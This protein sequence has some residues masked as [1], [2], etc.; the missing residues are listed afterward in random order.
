MPWAD[1]SPW[2]PG[3]NI[4]EKLTKFLSHWSAAADPLASMCW[5]KN[6][7]Y[8][9][10]NSNSLYIQIHNS[11]FHPHIGLGIYYQIM[12]FIPPQSMF[13]F[14]IITLLCNSVGSQI[15]LWNNGEGKLEPLTISVY[16]NKQPCIHWSKDIFELSSVLYYVQLGQ[17]NVKV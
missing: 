2:S 8:K 7:N 17:C 11:S 15:Y 14:A 4:S 10:Q 6:I 16:F 12:G 5:N 13:L 1:N 9:L 3:I